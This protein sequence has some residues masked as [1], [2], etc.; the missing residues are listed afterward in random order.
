[1][2]LSMFT[3]SS[4]SSPWAPTLVLLLSLSLSSS[5]WPL[6]YSL[7]A[8]PHLSP[9][10]ARRPLS[11]PQGHRRF[12][13]ASAPPL[14]QVPPWLHQPKAQNCLPLPQQ[15]RTPLC[16]ALGRILLQRI[17]IHQPIR[18]IHTRRSNS[19]DQPARR[20]FHGSVHSG[21]E[22]APEFRY[23]DRRRPPPPSH[24]PPRRFP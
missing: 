20:G 3:F 19:E 6:A 12:A 4:S 23:V 22:D 14:C 8:R 11:L 16:S 10:R 9:R 7:F 18:N 13:A 2:S 15:F 5:C 24:R 21:E 1:M 17:Q